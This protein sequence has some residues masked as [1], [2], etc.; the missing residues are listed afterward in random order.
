MPAET[1]APQPA[2]SPSSPLKDD[3]PA[4]RRR[5]NYGGPALFSFGFRPFFLAAAAWAALAILLWLP[6]FFGELELRSHLSA[7]EWHVH[8]MLFG[9]VAAAVAGFLL[10]AIPNWTG[11]LPVNGA[12][13]AGL[14]ALW[15]AGRIVLLVSAGFGAVAAVIDILFL[16]VLAA[17]AAREII[18]GKNWRNLRVLLALGLLILGNIVFHAEVLIG[19]FVDY[20][21]RISI[22]A[23]VLLITLIGGRIVPSFT[24]NWLTRN[25]P[26][27]LPIPFSRYDAATIA[28]SALALLGWVVAPGYEEGGALLILA[29]IMQVIRLARWAGDRTVSDRLLLMLHIGYA[30]VPLGFLLLGASAWLRVVP[31]SAG[32]HAWT[33][34]AVGSMTLA[35]MTRASLGHLKQPLVASAGTQA[36]Y[37]LVLVAALLRIAAAFVSTPGL[38]LLAG[39]IWV[40]AFAGFLICYGPALAGRPPSWTMTGRVKRDRK[41]G[42]EASA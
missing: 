32:I 34:G 35:V 21:T 4:L 42:T 28:V 27:R 25:N 6:Q 3:N 8:E 23:V 9:Y 13:L 41:A 11:R 36:I 38:L 30:F 15:L 14:A 10:T 33:A 39:L 16:L 7:L 40:A 31:E 20:G 19:G 29:G 2:P 24:N 12:S 17:V 22:G 37:A 1:A 18:A 5:R 26:G